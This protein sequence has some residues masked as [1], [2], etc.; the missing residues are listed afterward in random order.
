GRSASSDRERTFREQA[1]T[2]A[3]G[4]ES[5][6]R[7]IRLGV[8]ARRL[9]IAGV[10]IVATMAAAGWLT[11]SSAQQDAVSVK[12]NEIGGTVTGDKGPEAGV[13]VIAETRDLPT[14]FIKIVV[15]D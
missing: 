5:M 13:W 1:G 10:A 6:N 4:E 2:P 15:T 9:A 14:R 3:S 8:S 7:L 12:A 11:P